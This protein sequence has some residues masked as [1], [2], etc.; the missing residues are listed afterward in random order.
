[1]ACLRVIA[2]QEKPLTEKTR[3]PQVGSSTFHV[4]VCCF[5]VIL[6]HGV[7]TASW[8]AIFCVCERERERDSTSHACPLTTANLR[9]GLCRTP[10][11]SPICSRNGPHTCRPCADYTPVGPVLSPFLTS[12]PASPAASHG[13]GRPRALVPTLAQVLSRCSQVWGKRLQAA[14]AGGVRETLL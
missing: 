1:M 3:V 4:D 13:L 2:H 9:Q 8:L 14:R 11:C 12:P 6:E 7:Y 5:T 10:L